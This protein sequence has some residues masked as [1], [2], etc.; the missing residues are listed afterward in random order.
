MDLAEVK[1]ALLDP[2]VR[3]S[4]VEEDPQVVAQRMMN[5]VLSA[6]RIEDLFDTGVTHAA[7]AVDRPFELNNVE[8]R[9]SDVEGG[10]LGIFSVMHVTFQD[11]GE[12]GVVTCGAAG[13]V[14][15]LVKLV[16]FDALP[17]R[18][19][20]RATKTKGG[21]TALDLERVRDL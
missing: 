13:V 17:I 5:Q 2:K 12:I 20:I 14:T 1:A 21:Y 9:N 8:F 6:N 11:T 19:K 18:L 7:D 16:E 15:R 4:I 3:L 10:T